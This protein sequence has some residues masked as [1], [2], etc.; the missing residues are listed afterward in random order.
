MTVSRFPMLELP[1]REEGTLNQKT[2]LREFITVICPICGTWTETVIT[3]PETTLFGH[4][5]GPN[6]TACSVAN[7][8]LPDFTKGATIEDQ[9]QLRKTYLD[10]WKGRFGPGSTKE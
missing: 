6:G 7:Q 8:D 9:R 3:G 4:E 10:P 5:L 1:D 2:F